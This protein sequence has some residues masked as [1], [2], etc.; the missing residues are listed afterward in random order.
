MSRVTKLLIKIVRKLFT[1][2]YLNSYIKL[3]NISRESIDK[4]LLPVMAARLIEGIPE[5]EKQF[6][7]REIKQNL[8]NFY[9]EISFKKQLNHFFRNLI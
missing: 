5:P 2:Y 4:W 3:T 9:E 7:L 8:Q 1:R 6:L